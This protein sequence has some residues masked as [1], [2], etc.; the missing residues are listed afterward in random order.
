MSQLCVFELPVASRDGNYPL[1]D[2]EYGILFLKGCDGAG[3]A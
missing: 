1:Y 2:L 3:E